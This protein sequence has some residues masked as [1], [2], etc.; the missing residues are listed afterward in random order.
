MNL[1]DIYTRLTRNDSTAVEFAEFEELMNNWAWEEYDRQRSSA[2][3]NIA[4][5][6]ILDKNIEGF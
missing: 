4:I 2:T 5:K 3:G 1:K 6:N